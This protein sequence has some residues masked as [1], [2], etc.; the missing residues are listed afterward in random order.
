M[1]VALKVHRCTTLWFT[2]NNPIIN[3]GLNSD[4]EYYGRI[5]LQGRCQKAQADTAFLYFAFATFVFTAVLSHRAF[6]SKGVRGG[7]VV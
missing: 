7:A 4:H 1:T 5:D 6:R 2:S 3:G